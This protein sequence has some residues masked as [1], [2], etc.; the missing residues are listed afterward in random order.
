MPMASVGMLHMEASSGETIETSIN[1]R[2]RSLK[3]RKR[4]S[5]NDLLFVGR[6]GN[7]GNPF[8]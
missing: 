8:Y 6:I 1:G 2:R 5:K 4:P 7:I 3:E